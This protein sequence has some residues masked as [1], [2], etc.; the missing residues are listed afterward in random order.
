MGREEIVPRDNTDKGVMSLM[1]KRSRI[2]ACLALALLVI[3]L[4]ILAVHI[5]MKHSLNGT[6][7]VC[8]GNQEWL[9]YNWDAYVLDMDKGIKIRLKGVHNVGTEGFSFCWA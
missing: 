6:L 9:M 7:Y 5:Q 2:W 1:R 3:S 4:L 8:R